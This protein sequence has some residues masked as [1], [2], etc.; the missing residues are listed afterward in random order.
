[1][2]VRILHCPHCGDLWKRVRSERFVLLGA[3]WRQCRACQCWHESEFAEWPSLT[4][5]Q[6]FAFLAQNLFFILPLAVIFSTSVLICQFWGSV[7]VYDLLDYSMVVGMAL[8]GILALFLAWSGLRVLLSILRSRRGIGLSGPERN[9]GNKFI[10]DAAWQASV[11]AQPRFPV[12]EALTSPRSAAPE[13]EVPD[14]TLF[15][16]PA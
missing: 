15:L 13:R 9:P 10:S 7:P 1:M 3:P 16:H 6:R 5:G 4:W 2:S 12:Y 11:A 8:L 14:E